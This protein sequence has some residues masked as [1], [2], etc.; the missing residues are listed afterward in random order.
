M[1]K[2][3]FFLLLVVIGSVAQAQNKLFEAIEANKLEEVK[4]ALTEGIDVNLTV[5]YE[6]KG[7]KYDKFSP[8]LCAVINQ[9]PDIVLELL[10]KKA[11]VNA[12]TSAENAFYCNG[13]CEAKVSNLT[14][15]IQAAQEGN[16]EII[17]LLVRA[18]ADLDKLMKIKFKNK[19]CCNKYYSI[20]DGKYYDYSATELSVGPQSQAKNKEVLTLLK[21]AKYSAW[22][23]EPVK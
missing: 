18:K 20:E 7:V 11:K 13:E 22:A 8:L 9:N 6:R 23:K 16:I 3:L 21:K 14:P 5:I 19:K 4:A 17:K 10:R 15:I 2:Q 1:K 12:T